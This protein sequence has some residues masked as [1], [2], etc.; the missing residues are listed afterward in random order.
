MATSTDRV[1]TEA[2]LRLRA[3]VTNTPL[4]VVEFD[5]EYRIASFNARAEAVFGWSADEVVGRPTGEVGWVLEEDWPPVQ[6][7]MREISSGARPTTVHAMR[8]VRK[9]GS[10]IHCEWYSS[11]VYEP[12]GALASVLSL[13]L[14]VTERVRAEEARRVSEERLHR[15]LRLGGMIAWSWDAATDRLEATEH[16]EQLF[17]RARIERGREGFALIYPDDVERHRAIT[18]RARAEG[19]PY[20]SEYRVPL[21]NGRVVWLNERGEFQKDAA[22]R[23][24]RA[25][26]VTMDVTARKEAEREL[27]EKA[28]LKDQFEKVAL[29]VP[30]LICS[31]RLRPDGTASMPF[32]ATD[33]DAMFG[34]PSAVLR[35]D[36]GAALAHVHPDDAARVNDAVGESAHTMAPFHEEF[37][38]LHP[39]QGLRWREVWSRPKREPDGSI[40]WHGFVMDVTERKRAEQAL[41]DADRHKTEFLATLS[42]ELRNPLAPI[43]TCIELLDRLPPEDERAGRAKAI[44]RRQTDHLT[45]LVDDL[46]DVTRISRGKIELRRSRIELFDL[47]ARTCEDH[48][49]L[50]EARRVALSV[51]GRGPAWVDADP[52]RIAQVVGNLLQNASKF[53][54]EGGTVTVGVATA[55]GRAEI[56]VRDDGT[57]IPAELLPRVFEPFVQAKEGLARSQGGLG[58]GLALVKGLVELHG[59]GVRASSEVGRGAEFVVELPL[60]PPTGAPAPPPPSRASWR[61]LLILVIEDNV[62]AAQT[63]ADVLRLEGHTVHVATDGRSGL[64]K[65]RALGPEVIVCDI[66]LP[67]VDG[68]EL[69]RE[70]RADPRLRSTRLVALSGYAQPEDRR[71]AEE[72]GFDAHLGKPARLE[73]LSEVIAGGATSAPRPAPS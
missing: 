27:R 6:A 21:E 31:F 5:P 11:A 45:R 36:F 54:R 53:T 32:M 68:Y 9:D 1:R 65:A 41:R 30:G 28:A 16:S 58:L 7:L 40:I 3:H 33:A 46:L 56:R 57:G 18:E 29:S 64:A 13:V 52:T 12:G 51:A 42:H 39:T 55:N 37:R 24:Q 38:Y 60:A 2:A 22:G 67:D 20:R 26:G 23:V 15:A 14:D 50:F 71:R 10:V 63:V 73:E 59:G 62:D 49:L 66:G 69:A 17:G 8:N 34:I 72:A 19:G 48:R 47:V 61:P 44:I 43:R 25:V 4:A 70:L 35:D